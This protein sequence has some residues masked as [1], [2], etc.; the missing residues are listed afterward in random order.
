MHGLEV[1]GGG[2]GH[3]AVDHGAQHQG[4]EGGDHLLVPMEKKVF[5]FLYIYM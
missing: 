4:E 3:E 2:Q 5:I 1:T